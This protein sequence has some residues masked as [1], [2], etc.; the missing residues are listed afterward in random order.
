[1]TRRKPQNPEEVVADIQGHPERGKLN[2]EDVVRF[3]LE[4]IRVSVPKELYRV[5]LEVGGAMGLSKKEVVMM[6]LTRFVTDA[7]VMGLVE[8]SQQLK[9]EKFGVS[10]VEIRSKVFGA[11]KRVARSF[12]S[13]INS[14][15][16]N[17]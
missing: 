1:M 14:N 5:L 4:E 6:A 16:E 7:G 3:D 11:Y 8:R 2:G 17:S 15:A 12:N 13:R 9:S 10:K